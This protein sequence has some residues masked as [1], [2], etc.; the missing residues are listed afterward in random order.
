MSQNLKKEPDELQPVADPLLLFSQWFKQANELSLEFANAMT[1]ATVNEKGQPSARVV[2]LKDFGQE[3]FTFYSNYESDKAADLDF[4][5]KASLLFFGKLY[6]NR[7][8]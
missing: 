1:L 2:L 5:P 4:N 8:A 6:K 3:G 7:S